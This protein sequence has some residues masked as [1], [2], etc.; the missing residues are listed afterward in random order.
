MVLYYI[1]NATQLDENGAPEPT[2]ARYEGIDSSWV[3]RRY[4]HYEN[5]VLMEGT[6]FD[7]RRRLPVDAGVYGSLME[8]VSIVRSEEANDVIERLKED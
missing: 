4:D 3:R 5:G 7:V 1:G 8:E 2:Q 6:W